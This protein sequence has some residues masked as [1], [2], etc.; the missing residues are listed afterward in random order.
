MM[1]FSRF[2]ETAMEAMPV[3]SRAVPVAMRIV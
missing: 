2:F 3:K 1:L